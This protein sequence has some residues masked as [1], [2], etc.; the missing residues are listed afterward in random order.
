MRFEVPQFI[1]IEDKIVGPL[2]W[3]QF[4]YVAGG[5]GLLVILVLTVPFIIAI[6]I[7]IP[8]VAGA[9]FLAFHKVNNRPFSFFLESFFYYFTNRKLYLWRRNE[10]QIITGREHTLAADQVPPLGKTGGGSIASLSRKLELNN[11]QKR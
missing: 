2:T 11:L 5:A 6:F 4:V 9:G 10:P 7:G 1:E 8:V 3:K